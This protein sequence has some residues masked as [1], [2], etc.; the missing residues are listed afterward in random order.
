MY[1][2]TITLI[3]NI[4]H[5]L[6]IKQNIANNDDVNTTEQLMIICKKYK[7]IV[8][9]IYLHKQYCRYCL[10]KK[11]MYSYTFPNKK[12]LNHHNQNF[13]LGGLLFLCTEC[14]EYTQTFQENDNMVISP[15][16]FC[17]KSAQFNKKNII[18]YQNITIPLIST[19]IKYYTNKHLIKHTV[20][21]NYCGRINRNKDIV[22]FRCINNINY[23][24]KKLS[25]V[26]YFIKFLPLIN[27][28]HNYLYNTFISTF[29]DQ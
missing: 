26:F 25:Y 24:I 11:S 28:I 10:V 27:D 17:I 14:L 29:S 7:P 15:P 6:T 16:S 4:N 2:N 20:L 8:N 9:S 22:C 21:C 23:I 12:C 1:Y 18:F 5:T 13:D 3:P 19:K